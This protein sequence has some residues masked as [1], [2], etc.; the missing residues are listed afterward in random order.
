MKWFEH[1]SIPLWPYLQSLFQ[2]S[3]GLWNSSQLNI[4][5]HLC[6]LSSSLQ[7]LFLLSVFSAPHSYFALPP[8]STALSLPRPGI[9]VS[10]HAS[11]Q[12][13]S[14]RSRSVPALTALGEFCL[15][16]PHPLS[17]L[18]H[19]LLPPDLGS[20]FILTT[21]HWPTSP[22]PLT[23][24][25]TSVV[26]FCYLDLCQLWEQRGCFHF[27][28]VPS[29]SAPGRVSL[30]CMFSAFIRSPCST[31]TAPR[32]AAHLSQEM[33]CLARPP[34]MHFSHRISRTQTSRRA[35]LQCWQW[36][37]LGL[38][39]CF[40]TLAR[41]SPPPACAG[42][43][44]FLFCPCCSLFPAVSPLPSTSPWPL[45]LQRP[46]LLP[47]RA[48]VPLSLGS[49]SPSFP[50]TSSP[51]CLSGQVS[52]SGFGSFAAAGPPSLTSERWLLNPWKPWLNLAERQALKQSV[53]FR[54]T[55][56]TLSA[57]KDSVG[58]VLLQEADHCR[59]SS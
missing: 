59:L 12:P 38:A 50:G 57:F 5:L 6:P 54:C 39:A 44:D 22:R 16:R 37:C 1:I 51:P 20:D 41:H 55:S 15:S 8:P 10:P 4:W 14:L 3:L 27:R 52:P 40:P 18:P 46:L 53:D 24:G 34:W 33:H 36:K 21:A 32:G 35:W 47:A 30:C 9:L 25:L 17:C 42:G 31:P 19:A 56:P 29:C 11:P 48:R 13:W 49:P 43:R 26:C 7:A 28:I 2:S 45:P 23:S 58:L